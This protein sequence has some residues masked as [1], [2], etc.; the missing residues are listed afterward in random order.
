MQGNWGNL[1]TGDSAAAPRYIEARLT[2]FALEVILSPKVT[3]W[4]SSYDGRNKDRTTVFISA[5][6]T[7]A[8]MTDFTVPRKAAATAAAVSTGH[9]LITGC[10]H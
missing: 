2:P 7:V 6:D 9:A 5:V 10:G 3:T 4:A 1:L 8:L